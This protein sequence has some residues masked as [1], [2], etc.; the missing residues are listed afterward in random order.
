MYRVK[1]SALLVSLL[2]GL[3]P[4]H[5]IPLG[6]ELG[7]QGL[8]VPGVLHDALHRDP[9]LHICLENGIQQTSAAWRELH[10]QAC[11]QHVCPD[12]EFIECNKKM[13]SSRLLQPD[14]SCMHKLLV[15]TFVVI[16]S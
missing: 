7:G 6:L 13:A 14:D 10:A 2:L 16:H 5:L 9:L 1:L 11:G 4:H 3:H 15:N 12:T 8:P